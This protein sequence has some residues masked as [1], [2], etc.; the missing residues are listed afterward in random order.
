MSVGVLH[1]AGVVG[2]I[3]SSMDAVVVPVRGLDSRSGRVWERVAPRG[4][5]RKSFGGVLPVRKSR[6]RWD[7]QVAMTRAVAAGG[8]SHGAAVTWQSMVWA[9]SDRA[10]KDICARRSTIGEWLQRC[11]RTVRRHVAELEATGWLRVEH[12]VKRFANG[13]LR[14]LA[15]S[16]RFT[17]P[18]EYATKAPLGVEDDVEQTRV[19]RGQRVVNQPPQE[20]SEG[21]VGPDE[22]LVAWQVLD[23]TERA[24]R[25]AA[26]E[27][28]ARAARDGGAD[29]AA[30]I[31]RL[32]S[33]GF[34]GPEIVGVLRV[35]PRLRAGP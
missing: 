24:S 3:D 9:F 13:Q 32:E 34:L 29:D 33:A 27:D 5:P 8:V 28:L 10:G 21:A 23:D 16:Y 22:G 14:Q 4:W 35:L 12:R 30:V 19:E 26:A 20:P 7:A 15:N 31:A 17:V 11:P 25:R 18:P 1:D 6:W 2:V